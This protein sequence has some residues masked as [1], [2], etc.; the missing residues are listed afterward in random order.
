LG[1]SQQEEAFPRQDRRRQEPSGV[2]DPEAEIPED[3]RRI[4][5]D[6]FPVPAGPTL[7]ADLQADEPLPQ[8]LSLPQPIGEEE[9]SPRGNPP[10]GRQQLGKGGGDEQVDELGDDAV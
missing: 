9:I 2:R 7:Y 10:Y 3:D 6:G 4:T 5:E 8:A 1:A